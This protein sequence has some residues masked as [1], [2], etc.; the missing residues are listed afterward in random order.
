M[1]HSCKNGNGRADSGRWLSHLPAIIFYVHGH[2]RS[3]SPSSDLRKL[4]HV[5]AEFHWWPPKAQGR[6]SLPWSSLC[7]VFQRQKTLS[8]RRN[9]CQPFW[10]YGS[11]YEC[12]GS[13][14][15][16]HSYDLAT[17]APLLWLSKDVQEILLCAVC[18]LRPQ[19]SSASCEGM[20]WGVQILGQGWQWPSLVFDCAIQYKDNPKSIQL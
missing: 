14:L 11:P 10:G 16:S 18:L 17:A 7:P 4:C 5:K 3:H 19:S 2:V 12:M 9:Y 6:Y 13:L 15:I 8:R 20:T 1:V